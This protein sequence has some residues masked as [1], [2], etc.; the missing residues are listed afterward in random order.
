MYVAHAR[1]YGLEETAEVVTAKWSE[2]CGQCSAPISNI[3]VLVVEYV[4]IKRNPQWRESNAV[5][6][7]RTSSIIY[8]ALVYN[9]VYEFRSPLIVS[10]LK[11]SDSYL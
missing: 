5:N 8:I 2:R 3:Y 6:V 1:K 4:Q 10:I 11:R 9:I 7:K